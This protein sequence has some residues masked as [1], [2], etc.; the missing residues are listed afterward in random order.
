MI[1]VQSELISTTP[2]VCHVDPKTGIQLW[3]VLCGF[4]IHYYGMLTHIYFD[5]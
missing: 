3:L 2:H 4:V 1:P 5:I